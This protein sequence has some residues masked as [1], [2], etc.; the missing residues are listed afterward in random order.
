MNPILIVLRLVLPLSILKY[1]L[2][3]GIIAISLDNL[4]WVTKDL[5]GISPIFEYQL[6]DKFLDTYYL[7]FLALASL[8]FKN[9]LVK[10]TLTGLFIYRL[11]G[12]LIFEITQIRLVLFF[13]P[14]IFENLFFFYLIT[15]TIAGFEPNIKYLG[16]SLLTFIVS[17]PKVLQE[18]SIHVIQKHIEFN[19]FGFEYYYHTTWMQIA[20]IILFA[21]IFGI[22]F[23]ENKNYNTKV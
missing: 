13:F 2:L 22:Y 7:T 3:G 4:D 15:K 20:Y 21:L 11:I 1:P 10:N 14:N 18:Y 6:I 17:I 23:R 5:F 16:L 8:K 12:F 9:K 19:I